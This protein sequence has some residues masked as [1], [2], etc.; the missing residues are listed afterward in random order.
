MKT[1]Q[2][3]LTILGFGLIGLGTLNAEPGAGPAPKDKGGSPEERAQ[4]RLERLKADLGLSPEQVERIRKIHAEELGR[5]QTQLREGNKSEDEKREAWRS[6]RKRTQF[7]VAEVLTPE[8]KEKFAKL[9]A[10]REAKGEPGKP[11]KAPQP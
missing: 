3:I 9:V 7:A 2:R 10:K 11:G 4:R 6:S 8:Q 1:Q 5:L